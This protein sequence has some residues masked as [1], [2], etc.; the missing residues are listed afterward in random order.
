[1]IARWNR[2][3]RFRNSIPDLTHDEAAQMLRFGA[4]HGLDRVTLL[5]VAERAIATD[6]GEGELRSLTMYR[7]A[8]AAGRTIRFKTLP[9]TIL[10]PVND[11]LRQAVEEVFE[12]DDYE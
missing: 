8:I 1:V 9:V 7:D 10:E 11:E 5:A 2:R 12:G 4:R 6:T 3:R